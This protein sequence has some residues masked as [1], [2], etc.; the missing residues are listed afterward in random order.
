MPIYEYLCG[1]CDNEFEYLV[2]GSDEP[3]NCPAC[4]SAEVCRQMSTCGFLSKSSGGE[5]VKSSAGA[6]A[7]S[8]CTT[9]SCAGCGH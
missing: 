9:S 4:D 2:L 3:Q 7:C 1:N 8:G 5:T 6:S